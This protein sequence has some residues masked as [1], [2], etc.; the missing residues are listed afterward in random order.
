MREKISSPEAC[1]NLL[2]KVL[3]N[4]RLPYVTITPVF[5]V[6]KTHGYLSGEHAY[7]PKCDEALLQALLTE[8]KNY[9]YGN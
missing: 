9:L 8:T 3:S 5:S 7:C 2:R 6:C 1:R 4:F